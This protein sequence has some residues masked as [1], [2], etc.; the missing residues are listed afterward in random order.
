MKKHI[1]PASKKIISHNYEEIGKS[2]K[3][4]IYIYNLHFNTEWKPQNKTSIFT[5]SKLSLE[6]DKSEKMSSAQ[7]SS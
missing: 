5:C 7:Y 3:K 1:N 2:E 4:K 6:S